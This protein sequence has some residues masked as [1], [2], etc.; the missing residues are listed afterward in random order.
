MPK[1][2]FRNGVDEDSC[3]ACM[4]GKFCKTEGLS[5]P[6]DRCQAGKTPL[7]KQSNKY[8]PSTP[9]NNY[10]RFQKDSRVFKMMLFLTTPPPQG[11][12]VLRMRRQAAQP[13]RA[14]CVL[15]AIIVRL[16][17]SSQRPAKREPTQI[18]QD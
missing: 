6:T 12:T 8:H 14:S 2:F 3:I 17:P 15:K 7:L 16:A 13:L 10:Y 18:S 11:F 1:L 4:K 5:A 9:S